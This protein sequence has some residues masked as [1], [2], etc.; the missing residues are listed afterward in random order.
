VIALAGDDNICSDTGMRD[1]AIVHRELTE[2][3]TAFFARTLK[4]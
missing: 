2:D 3:I 1:R 4:P